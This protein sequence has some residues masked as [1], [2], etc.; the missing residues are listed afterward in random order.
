MVYYNYLALFTSLC[1]THDAGFRLWENAVRELYLLSGQEFSQRKWRKPCISTFQRTQ[2]NISQRWSHVWLNGPLH[3]YLL[4]DLYSPRSGLHIFSSRI[5]RPIVGIHKLLTDAWMWKL[6][7]WPRYSFSGNIC[8]EISAFCL[9]SAG[10]L[11][12][13]TEF[14]WKSPWLSKTPAWLIK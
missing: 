7:L 4:P 11:K 2:Q 13:C 1:C 6:G 8:F 12:S 5:G 14:G 9:C 10:C 3:E